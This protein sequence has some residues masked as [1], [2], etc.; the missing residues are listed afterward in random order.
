MSDEGMTKYGVQLDD[1]K[2]KEASEATKSG[3]HCPVCLK[4]LDNGGACPTHGTEPFE[5][6]E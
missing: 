1:Q 5:K 2:V 6:K 4:K 3:T